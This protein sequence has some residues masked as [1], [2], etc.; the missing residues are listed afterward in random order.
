MNKENAMEVK[1]RAYK[2]IA[3][4]DQLVAE[5]RNKCPEE[6]LKSVRRAVGNS[7]VAINDEILEPIYKQYP[8]LDNQ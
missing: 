5:I 6:E 7:I 4:L 8:E 1:R 2:A 3:E